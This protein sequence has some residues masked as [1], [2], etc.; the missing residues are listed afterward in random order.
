MAAT[1]ASCQMI[2]A[3]VMEN[4]HGIE[5][6]RRYFLRSVC[7]FF[8]FLQTSKKAKAKRQILMTIYFYQRR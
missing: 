3:N 8:T 6:E 7:D 2:E 5:V 1:L 4:Y